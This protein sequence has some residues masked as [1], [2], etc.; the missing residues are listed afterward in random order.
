MGFALLSE[1]FKDHL[2]KPRNIGD[3]AEPDGVGEVTGTECGD[4]M[5]V[6][7]RVGQG[8]ITDIRF[9]T[10]GCWAAIGAASM[11]TEMA[12]GMRVEEAERLSRVDFAGD[13]TGIPSDKQHCIELG[14]LAL[15]RAIQDYQFHST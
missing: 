8:R 11:L 1:V 7:I 15:R 14:M 10:F 2:L 12:R 5:T 9:K 4:M 6:Y 3:M 13:L